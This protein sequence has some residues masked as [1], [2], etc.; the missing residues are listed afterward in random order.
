[1]ALPYLGD[2]VARVC[3]ECF[4]RGR[5]GRPE[6][7]RRVSTSRKNRPHNTDQG[8]NVH[9]VVQADDNH[10]PLD[11]ERDSQLLASFKC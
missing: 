4:L 7:T 1:M 2:Q 6:L 11:L 3:D 10:T 9:K 5:K 8:L